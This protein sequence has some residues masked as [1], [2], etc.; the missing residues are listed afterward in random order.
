MHHYIG[1][2]RRL[3][4]Q[5]WGVSR[6]IISPR[7]AGWKNLYICL[8]GGLRAGR[9]RGLGGSS[10]RAGGGDRA[11]RH[12]RRCG[13]GVQSLARGRSGV[14]FEAVK[15]ARARVHV[16]LTGSGSWMHSSK[17]RRRAGSWRRSRWLRGLRGARSPIKRAAPVS[18]CF[19]AVASGRGSWRPRDGFKASR[20]RGRWIAGGFELA[21]RSSGLVRLRGPRGRRWWAPVGV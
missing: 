10:V 9:G 20:A 18:E 1:A 17:R 3:K 7:G 14:V 11:G 5:L 4:K 16:G 21:G 12:P 15:A 6:A 19:E 13:L 2:R 8:Y